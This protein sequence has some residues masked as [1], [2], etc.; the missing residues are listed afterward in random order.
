MNKGDIAAGVA[1]IGG[2]LAEA[3]LIGPCPLC[4][5]AIGGGVYKIK[6]GLG[7]KSECNGKP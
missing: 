2:G 7:K 5:A 6:E 3:A 1:L 4:I